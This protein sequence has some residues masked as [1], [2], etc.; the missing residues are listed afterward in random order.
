MQRNSY[1]SLSFFSCFDF[2]LVGFL[3]TTLNPRSASGSNFAARM[4]SRH[5]LSIETARGRQPAIGCPYLTL[6]VHR[7][8]RVRGPT[9]FN[10]SNSVSLVCGQR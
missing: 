3:P 4:A 8:T 1:C 5:I 7:D 9:R 6:S 2:Q 10:G